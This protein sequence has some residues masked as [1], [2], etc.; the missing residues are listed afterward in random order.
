MSMGFL[1][2]MPAQSVLEIICGL[3]KNDL[4]HVRDVVVFVKVLA[5]LITSA[6][7]NELVAIDSRIPNMGFALYYFREF[8]GLDV[9][10][11]GFSS[12]AIILLKDVSPLMAF[13]LR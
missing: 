9:G 13:F 6:G 5:L 4:L 8:G 10:S 12:R 2:T 1:A 7:R 11:D 3:T